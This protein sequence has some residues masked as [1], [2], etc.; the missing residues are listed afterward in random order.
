[1]SRATSLVSLLALLS[2]GGCQDQE[3]P[4]SPT[5]PVPTFSVDVASTGLLFWN[6]E[7]PT[8]VGTVSS[9]TGL[10]AVPGITGTASQTCGGPSELYGGG[11]VH[12]T[13]TFGVNNCYP[14]LDVTIAT[15][16]RLT[17]LSF[18]HWHN[19]NPGF[20]TYPQYYAQLQIGQGGTFV[21]IGAPVLLSNATSTKVASI[22][23]DRV[24]AAGTY[25][26]RWVPRGLAY[27][28]SHTGSEFFAVDNVGLSGD[29]LR[30]PVAVAG[31]PYTV[32][33]GATLTFDG[34][35][36]WH[37]DGDALS[38]AWD[39]DA[40]G[41]FEASGARPSRSYGDDAHH[42]ITLR[43]TDPTGLSST[44]TAELTVTNVV[45]VVAEIAGATIFVGEAYARSGSFTDPGT[46][47][48]T[49]TVDFGEGAEVLPL[50]GMTY[51]FEHTYTVAGSYTVAVT[52]SDDDGGQGATQAVVIVLSPAQATQALTTTVAELVTSGV[53]DPGEATA[54]MASL[55][56]AMEQ[57]ERGN[58]KA[59]ENQ[60][61]AFIN[62][63]EAQVRS[64]RLN[65][66]T[67]QQLVD[68]GRRIIASMRP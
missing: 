68:S 30:P 3:L 48:W 5:P 36:S 8:T 26:I 66:L 61:K 15:G 49:A 6:F 4:T 44:A 50:S 24:L 45:P 62:K 13:R 63:V 23:L 35:G 67:G 17:S 34:S 12:L 58:V 20:A 19:H 16:A 1:M 28:R 57:L 42:S 9:F 25:R 37:P 38:F 56:A 41:V 29:I 31:G 54:L 32:A 11:R 2:V 22:A 59:A 33:E 18:W 21:D 55:D 47:S 39:L 60:V 52:V 14:Y 51:Q 53:L 64:R 43:V 40:D 7:N 65:A 27:N 46:D 10:A